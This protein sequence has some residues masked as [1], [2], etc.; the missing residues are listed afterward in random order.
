MINWAKWNALDT[1]VKHCKQCKRTTYHKKRI[2][3]MWVEVTCNK[4]KKVV[5]YC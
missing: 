4:C 5:D 2:V 3:G 1:K